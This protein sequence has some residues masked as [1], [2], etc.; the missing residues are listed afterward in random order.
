MFPLDEGP[1][2]TPEECYLLFC[3]L[4][5]TLSSKHLK[6]LNV[7]GFHEGDLQLTNT[8]VMSFFS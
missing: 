4:L 5:Q 8:L 2:H 6:D 1:S 7:T 3:P